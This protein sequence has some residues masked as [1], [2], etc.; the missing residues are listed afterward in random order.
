M[1]CLEDYPAFTQEPSKTT[2]TA[3]KKSAAHALDF[4][5]TSTAAEAAAAAAAATATKTAAD[6][7]DI[8][9]PRVVYQDLSDDENGESSDDEEVQL[10][11]Q[12]YMRAMAARS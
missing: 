4:T 11:C 5:S 8:D 1:Q 12:R 3:S 9:I 10:I 7:F 6:A 2:T